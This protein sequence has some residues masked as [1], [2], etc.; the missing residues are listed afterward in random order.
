MARII[1][2]VRPECVLIENSPNLRTR[3]LVRV[4][5]DLAAMGYDAKWGVLGALGFG[6]DHERERM[7]IV[8]HAYGP[9]L[10]GGGLPSGIYETDADACRS[11]WWK[12]QPG[13]ERVANGVPSQMDRLKAIGNAQVP[14]VVRLAWETLKP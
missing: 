1:G 12:N 8:A 6:A 10:K 7:F 11:D 14:A 4:L 13:L 2:E 9:Q 5:K 3:G